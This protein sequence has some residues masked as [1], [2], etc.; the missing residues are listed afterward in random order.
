MP[1]EPHLFQTLRAAILVAEA[2]ACKAVKQELRD[3]GI[4]PWSVAMS[5]IK[6]QAKA[7]LAN[8]P[9]LLEEGKAI[10]AE[11]HADTS[12]SSL[13]RDGEVSDAQ[14]KARCEL[15]GS[16]LRGEVIQRFRGYRRRKA[17]RVWALDRPQPQ[18]PNGSSKLG[19]RLWRI[20]GSAV[21]SPMVRLSTTP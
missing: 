18:P 4:K 16:E 6:L 9:E 14:A 19:L 5:A 17:D 15:L 21:I 3:Q 2:R 7:Y 1:R 10:C 12:A 20:K 8:H 11:L 13:G